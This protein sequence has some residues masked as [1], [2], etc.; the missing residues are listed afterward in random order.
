MDE[1]RQLIGQFFGQFL[2]YA[3]SAM[4]RRAMAAIFTIAALAAISA[5]PRAALAQD[6]KV[7]VMMFGSTWE[8]VF[9][10]LA[11]AFKQETGIE[12]V[13]VI[14][15]SSIEGL[16]KIQAMRDKPTVD[17]WFT[18]ESIAIRAAT[19]KG[20]FV[21]LPKDKIPN[22]S[23]LISGSHTDMFVA[24]WYFPVGIIYRP[25][26]VPGGKITSWNELFTPAFKNEVALPAPTVY[27]G[28]AIL[29][30]ALLN[31]GSID[32]IEPGLKFLAQHK[33][34][35]A[36][37][38]SSDTNARRALARGEIWAMMGSPSAV[39]EL[40][41]QNIPAAMVSPKPTPLI[42]E[43]MMMV[44]SGN[45]E[46]AAQFINRALAEDWQRHMT[47]VYNLGPVNKNVPPA[48]ALAAA[49]PKEGDAVTFDEA[50]INE[51]LGS[52][53]ERFN[54]AIGQ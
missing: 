29:V 50:V 45:E 23:K 38:H 33:S 41:D 40:A 30:A 9:K 37:F 14:E 19:D 27:P 18:G 15:N 8:K 39:K 25:D 26:L 53:T 21:P 5:M 24:Y 34:D 52:W 20:L 16:A 32:D 54:A 42:F 36:M 43:G 46:V 12:I 11:P 35:I 3:R 17:V 51:R 28:R 31:G 13:P 44:K 22:L 4:K 1:T 48:A 7:N 6:R 10:P 49:M 2:G 47:E